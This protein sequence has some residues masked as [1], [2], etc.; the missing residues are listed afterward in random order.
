MKKIFVLFILLSN[1]VFGYDLERDLNT[2]FKHVPRIQ[3]IKIDGY[4]YEIDMQHLL[5][6]TMGV[7]SNFGKDKYKGR[8]AKSPMQFEMTTAEHYVKIVPELKIYLESKLN[9]KLTYNDKDCVFITYLIY[10]SKL[11]YHTEWLTKY[12]KILH[13]TGDVEW[14]VYKVMWNSIKGASTYNKWKYR[15][16]LYY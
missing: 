14:L 4:V 15:Y 6:M 16:S 3:E 12:K 13:N 10:M 8:I 7:E 9:R 5:I 1:I 2:L 11:Q